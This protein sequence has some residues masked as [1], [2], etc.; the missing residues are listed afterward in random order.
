MG[1]LLLEVALV[2][3]AAVLA[4]E[5]VHSPV[6]ASEAA[7]LCG[8]SAVTIRAWAN[9]GYRGADGVVVKLPVIG[10]DRQGRNLYRLLDVAKAEHATRARA[11]RA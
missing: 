9:R 10:R 6:T 4:P 3:E 11:R 8:V 1:A 5:G 7:S 2:S